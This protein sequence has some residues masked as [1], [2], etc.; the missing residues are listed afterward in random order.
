MTLDHEEV[1]ARAQAEIDF[2]R[3][4]NQAFWSIIW[5]KIRGESTD[6]LNFDEVR[7]KLRLSDERYLGRQEIPLDSIVGSV[8]RYQD[9]TRKFLPKRT[10]NRDRWKAID[11]LTLGSIG[12]PPI[13]VYKVGDAYFV[14]DGN[15]RV[16]V[17]R[18]NGMKTIEAYVTEWSTEVPF[19][20]DTTPEDLF[21]KEGY[22]H[23]LRHTHLKTLRPD[24][25]V[26]L[27]EPSRYPAILEHIQVHH[28]YLGLDCKCPVTWSEAVA[29]WYD[30]VY[31]PMVEAI[32]KHDMLADL[33]HR[34]EADLYVW[35]I[36]HQGE[37]QEAYG[38]EPMSPDD[39]VEDFIEK[40]HL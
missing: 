19:D 18:A 11:A 31:L 26:V 35:L 27:T 9:F 8:G 5:A 29:S 34:T 2:Q 21:I 30:N 14:L 39:T 33:P 12:F 1:S 15:H 40:T 38:G 6:L 16:S 10:V 13:E 23:F 7:Q 4:R 17:A 25:D 37:M 36:Q 22:A 28:Y 20:K 32:R 3:A 24:S